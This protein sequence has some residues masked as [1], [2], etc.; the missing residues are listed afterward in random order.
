MIKM[1]TAVAA[2]IIMLLTVACKKEKEASFSALGFWKG[3]F[4]AY[5]AALVNRPDGTARIYIAFRNSDTAGAQLKLDGLYTSTPDSYF[6]HFRS[7]TDTITFKA[8]RVSPGSM[9]GTSSSP[10]V[11]TLGG[12]YPT[13]FFKEP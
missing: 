12:A 8:R 2:G 1:I 10:G 4:F 3:Y 7:D 9:A 5:S 11:D 6:G 13:E